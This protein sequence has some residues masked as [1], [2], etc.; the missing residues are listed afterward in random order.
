MVNASSEEG[1]LAVNGM[2]YSKRDG[3]NANSAVVVSVM[4]EDFG[5]SHPLGG[6]AFQRRLEEKAYEVGQGKVP[7]ERYG[8]FRQAVMGQ[9]QG[10]PETGDG[11]WEEGTEDK[12]CI[13]SDYLPQ[14]KGQWQFAP[15]HDIM[16]DELNCAFLEGMEAFGHMIDGFAS[17]QVLL[18]GI[19]SRT[20]S[21]VRIHRDASGQSEIGGL[22]P[23]GEG[24]GYAGGITSAAMDGIRIAE[25]IAKEYR[26]TA[27]HQN[28]EN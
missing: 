9:M 10:R 12:A 22:Y 1:R 13:G 4:P 3:V 16:P 2:S 23:C 11:V 28:R 14:I 27:A 6:L 17:G 15:V 26:P 5:S 20:S 18:S 21:P 7:V 19:E 24:A 8:D 25:L